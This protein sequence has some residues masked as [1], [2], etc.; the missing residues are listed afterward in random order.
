MSAGRSLPLSR[1]VSSL[2]ND[3]GRDPS[4][5]Q[6]TFTTSLLSDE[7]VLLDQGHSSRNGTEA[8]P[9]KCTLEIARAPDVKVHFASL[10]E[11]DY[12][13]PH[14]SESSQSNEGEGHGKT[15]TDQCGNALLVV[16][17]LSWGFAE[18]SSTKC[19]RKGDS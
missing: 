3:G 11:M 10:K 2:R 7:V 9:H 4:F 15:I 18:G 19:P 6:L 12:A 13:H 5:S 1:P 16:F 14:P 17:W 8:T